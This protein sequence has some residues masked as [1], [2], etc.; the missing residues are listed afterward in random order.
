MLS[1]RNLNSIANIMNKIYSK[2]TFIKCPS[3]K[4]WKPFLMEKLL[5]ICIKR[6]TY[7]MYLGTFVKYTVTNRVHIYICLVCNYS[8]TMNE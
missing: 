7:T 5:P 2:L 6:T 3:S 4:S 8:A 1:V